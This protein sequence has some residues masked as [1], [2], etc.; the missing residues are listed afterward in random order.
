MKREQLKG[1]LNK[2]YQSKV[3]LRIKKLAEGKSL[4]RNTIS[5]VDSWGKNTDQ[6]RTYNEKRPAEGDS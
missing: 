3:D 2:K 1:T 5:K 4:S 6:G